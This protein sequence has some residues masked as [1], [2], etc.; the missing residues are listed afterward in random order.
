M[1]PAVKWQVD[2]ECY[3][4]LCGRHTDMIGTI[5]NV[6]R[7]EVIIDGIRSPART[8]YLVLWADHSRTFVREHQMRP[9]PIADDA[10]AYACM[11]EAL[12]RAAK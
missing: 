2:D 8:M 7:E 3:G 10:F 12:M 11:M 6:I 9:V 4:V 5:V 1:I